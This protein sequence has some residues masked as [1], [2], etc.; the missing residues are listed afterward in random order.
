MKKEEKTCHPIVQVQSGA[1]V[2]D[3]VQINYSPLTTNTK[4]QR[5]GK[6]WVVTI[7]LCYLATV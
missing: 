3:E 7:R 1:P 2:A 4:D 6:G 5:R